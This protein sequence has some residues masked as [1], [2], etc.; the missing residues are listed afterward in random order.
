MFEETVALQAL[1]LAFFGMGPMEMI[2]V[3]VIAVLLFGSRLPE[4]ARS[5]G[6]SFVEF[7]KGIHGV[8]SEINDAI[9]ST[10][11]EVSHHSDLE[12]QSDSEDRE[13]PAAPK[14]EPP[15]GESQSAEDSMDGTLPSGEADRVDSP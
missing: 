14:F 7:K 11:A 10:T 2:I 6:K 9:Y 1:P 3:G 13:E 8:E 5:L 4:V 15:A 12:Y